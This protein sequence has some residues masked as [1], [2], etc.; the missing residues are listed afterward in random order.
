MSE[1]LRT[2]P[3]G[4]STCDAKAQSCS[5][6]EGWRHGAVGG[7]SAVLSFLWDILRAA[8]SFARLVSREVMWRSEHQGYRAVMAMEGRGKT[9]ARRQGGKWLEGPGERW[10]GLN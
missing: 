1:A 10:G 9:G 3:A 8:G 4:W 5:S 2:A 7:A 6:S